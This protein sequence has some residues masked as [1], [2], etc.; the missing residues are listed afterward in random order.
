[1]DAEGVS[2][3]NHWR[4]RDAKAAIRTDQALTAAPI[5]APL[6]FAPD[7]ALCG[8]N[9]DIPQVSLELLI[10]AEVRSNLIRSGLLQ[11]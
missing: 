9:E 2:V 4:H 6:R 11:R 7:P 8:F 10:W 5:D 1:M 3:S